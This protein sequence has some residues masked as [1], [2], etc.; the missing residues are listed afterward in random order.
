MHREDKDTSLQFSGVAFIIILI[1]LR[2][3]LFFF[4]ERERE[5]GYTL[6]FH[7]FT[8]TI[9]KTS[10]IIGEECSEKIF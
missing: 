5:L 7:L 6:S 9:K 10:F 2:V 4:V 8:L 3:H 1:R